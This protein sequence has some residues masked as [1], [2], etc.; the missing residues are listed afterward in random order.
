MLRLKIKI[1]IEGGAFAL[2]DQRIDFQNAEGHDNK[3]EEQGRTD[4]ILK[5]DGD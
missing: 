2:Q 5:I 1:Q 3:Q 4:Q